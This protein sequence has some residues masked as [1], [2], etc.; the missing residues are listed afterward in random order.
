MYN[1]GICDDNYEI[2]AQIKEIIQK[3][4]Q[5]SNEE[6]ATYLFYSGEDLYEFLY[7]R[8]QLDLIFLD[9]EMAN[10]N[11]VDLGIKIRSEF[12]NEALQIV[13]ISGKDCYAMDLFQTRPLNFLIKPLNSE[14]IVPLIEK[15]IELN[16]RQCYFSYKINRE[17]FR[18]AVNEILYFESQGRRI[19]MLTL[20]NEVFFYEKLTYVSECVKEHQFVLIHHSILV[21]YNKISRFLHDQVIMENGDVLPI[22]QKYWKAFKQIQSLYDGGSRI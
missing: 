10:L 3:F 8:N 11:G 9:I 6:I 20:K 4:A 1:I 2:V 7:K 15:V 5:K 21:N 17:S 12:K 16:A 19:R 13:Y 14:K 22:S 18:I